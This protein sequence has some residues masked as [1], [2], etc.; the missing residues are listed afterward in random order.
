MPA[1][2]ANGPD[3]PG[4]GVVPCRDP[5]LVSGQLS[6]LDFSSLFSLLFLRFPV[7]SFKQNFVVGHV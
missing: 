5:I 4:S 6:D 1:S 2:P 7:C 3:V